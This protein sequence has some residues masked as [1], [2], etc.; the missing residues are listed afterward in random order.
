[1][2]RK[3][4]VVCGGVVWAACTAGHAE[5]SAPPVAPPPTVTTVPMP[6]FQSSGYALEQEPAAPWSLTAS[7]G[8][9]LLLARVDAKAVVQGPLAFTE[10]HLYFHNLEDRVREGTFQIA[11][12]NRAAVSRFAMETD[13]KM[14]EAEVVEKQLARRAYEDF[15]HRRQDPA[16]LEKAA[17]NQFTAR[18]FPIPPK[19][20]KHIVISFSQELPGERYLLPLRGLPKV[21]RVDVELSV[22]GADGKPA[23][24]ALA[25][26]NWQPDKD[27]VSA[28][29]VA[30]QAIAAGTDIAAQIDIPA[31]GGV[32]VP[33]GLTLLFDTSASRTL[34]FARSVD[35]LDK[36]IASVRTR[37][38]AA[39]PLQVVAFDQDTQAIYDGPASGWGDGAK[40]ALL[41]RG[42]AGASD[43]GQVIAWLGAHAPK[44]RV[45]VLTDG[46][47]TA[48]S[49]QAA[50]ASA[51][52][53][54]RGVER[55]D[56]VL[57]GGIRDEAMASAL[58]RASARPGA[59]LDLET[60]LDAVTAG[61][62]ERVLVD[63]AIDVPGAAW[64]FPRRIPSVRAGSHVMVYA[65][66]RSPQA[67]IDVAVNGA[68]RTIRAAGGTDALVSRALAAAHIAQLEGELATATGPAA[69]T[70]RA[71]IAKRSVA[72]RVVSSQT[73]LLVLE[74]ESDYAR[75]GIGR[76]ALA[77]IL[78]I[79]GGAVVQKHRTLSIATAP[80]APP[81]KPQVV[82]EAK[83]TLDVKADYKIADKNGGAGKD[84]DGPDD[85]D[86][87]KKPEP[88]AAE[89]GAHRPDR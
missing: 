58:V 69:A 50:L 55:V 51:I 78:A 7:D 21:E 86:A 19:A 72:A 84:E 81:K 3:L 85:G 26:R 9:G 56:F 43:L 76:T 82:K 49:D 67:S 44:A 29:P 30:A 88:K 62:G 40:R 25:Q 70:L 22:Y 11:L 41:A 52:K 12:P 17:G 23:K 18:V 74:T 64:V 27:F 73:S 59:V 79:E 47:V 39:M 46:V 6:V 35:A 89:L 87:E 4:F 57:A 53:G 13:G 14:M 2:L 10:L 54:L 60:G 42:A 80:V 36:L 65:Q 16:L 15:L 45:A 32:D 37:Y 71:E 38:G 61:L 5:T 24:Q 48:G 20:N 1:M 28:A 33:A 8:S 63:V 31:A 77:D 34:G 68:R 75:F 66:T 83:K